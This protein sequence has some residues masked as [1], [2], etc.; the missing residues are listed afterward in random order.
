MIVNALTSLL[1]AYETGPSEVAVLI[2][3]DE[4][5]RELNRDF[6]KMDCA[7]DVL[8]FP[9]QLGVLGDIAISVDT[10]HKQ[11][12]ARGDSL[13][14]EIV[15]LAIH[16]GLH[17][18]GFEDETDTGRDEMVR[19]MNDHARTLGMAGDDGWSSLPHDEEAHGAS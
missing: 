8:T 9:G 7:T 14:N 1:D 12:E 3:G 13:E 6:R 2:T 18:L 5:I 19:R 11:A 4:K 17:L 16:G 15:Y 10:A